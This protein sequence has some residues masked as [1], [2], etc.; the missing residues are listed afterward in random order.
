MSAL[1]LA[2]YEGHE[3]AALA[4]LE[5]ADVKLDLQNKVHQ[6]KPHTQSLLSQTIQSRACMYE[7]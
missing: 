5:S 7:L 2:V 4:L 1:M 6:L 3:A